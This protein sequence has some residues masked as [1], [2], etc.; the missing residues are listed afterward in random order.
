MQPAFQFFPESLG[1]LAFPEQ[2]QKIFNFSSA[3]SQNAD[4]PTFGVWKQG[5]FQRDLPQHTV[6]RPLPPPQTI[7]NI[8]CYACTW[9][10]NRK[11]NMGP[12]DEHASSNLF[13]KTTGREDGPLKEDW[14]RELRKLTDCQPR[15]KNDFDFGT[16]LRFINPFPHVLLKPTCASVTWR[17]IFILYSKPGR[18]WQKPGDSREKCETPG[19]NV[20]VW[21]SENVHTSICIFPILHYKK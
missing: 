9:F 16:K 19:K 1:K 13:H 10:C 8:V 15:S 21:M 14:G 3:S 11:I 18:F 2:V 5:G 4:I 7:G 6:T 12:G 20:R 17:L